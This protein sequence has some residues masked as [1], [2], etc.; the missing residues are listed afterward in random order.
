[1]RWKYALNTLSQVFGRLVKPFSTRGD[2]SCPPPQ[3]S[4]PSAIPVSTLQNKVSLT[5]VMRIIT[6]WSTN[7]RNLSK[8]CD[9]NIWFNLVILKKSPC[10]QPRNAS[11][12]FSNN[13][14]IRYFLHLNDLW[15]K[16]WKTCHSA[17]WDGWSLSYG[18]F[19]NYVD[20]ILPYFEHLLPS[21]GQL[22]LFCIKLT[23]WDRM[24]FL[25]NTYS[26]VQIRWQR[27]FWAENQ[28]NY[29]NF[30]TSLLT[31]KCWLIFMSMKQKKNFFL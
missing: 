3:I 5:L 10:F 2:R 30:D 31:Y 24:D 1:M 21:S 12:S 15:I 28:G 17:W 23:L 27:V 7:F 9:A 26:G 8:N 29:Q 22:G 16:F 18:T 11:F 20:Q 25:Q 4:R 13:L 19:N 14:S 6:V